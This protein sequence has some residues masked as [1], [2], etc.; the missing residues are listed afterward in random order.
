VSDLRDVLL[1]IRARHGA[2]TPAV[3]VAEARAEDHPLH[4]RFEW[5]DSVAA[6]KYRV[7]QAHDLIQSYRVKY[8]EHDGKRPAGWVRGF[9]AVQSPD[10]FVYDPAEEV[11]ADPLRRQMVLRDM[12]RD[13]RAL[14]ARYGQFAEFADL[15][16][17][18][19]E[20]EVA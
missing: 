19:L 9:H 7:Q 17:R 1:D 3:V 16:Q 4:H 2:L 8:R 5:D 10:G 13:W 15:V 11:A 18:D 6:E 14:K 20:G 12:E